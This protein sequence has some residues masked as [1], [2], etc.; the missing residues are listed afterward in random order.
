MGKALRGINPASLLV[1]GLI[2]LSALALYVT[3]QLPDISQ[4]IVEQPYRDA[5][6]SEMDLLINDLQDVTRNHYD[7][8]TT[9]AS[10]RPNKEIREAIAI[11]GATENARL[12]GDPDQN[13]MGKLADLRNAVDGLPYKGNAPIRCSKTNTAGQIPECTAYINAVEAILKIRSND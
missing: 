7:S 12:F 9:G 13:L 8:V 11:A 3:I 5:E 2:V 4:A 1:S 10:S 6:K